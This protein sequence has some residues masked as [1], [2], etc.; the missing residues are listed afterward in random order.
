MV[1]MVSIKAKI[2]V[3]VFLVIIMIAFLCGTFTIYRKYRLQKLQL[4]FVEENISAD[5]DIPKKLRN[6][7]IL[8]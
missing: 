8:I 5:K 4:D 7:K 1:L 3:I 6:Q 2:C